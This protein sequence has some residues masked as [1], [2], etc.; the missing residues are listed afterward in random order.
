VLAAPLIENGVVI[1]LLSVQHTPAGAYS[2][3]DLHL[4][5]HLAERVSAAVA[6]ARVFEE[7]EDYRRTLEERVAERTRELQDANRDKER[8]IAAL[9]ERSRTLERES[10]EDPLTGIANRRQFDQRLSA[11][12]AAARAAEQ[13]LTLAVADLDHFKIVND[14]LGHSVGD[15]V[16]RHTAEIMR[17]QCRAVD[18]VARIG[19]EEF[20]LVLSG[21]TRDVAMSYCDLLRR[22]FESHD[23][24]SIHPQLLV[25][26]SIGISQ[27]DGSANPAEFLRAAD[28]Q[29]YRAKDAGRNRVA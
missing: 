12:I 22:A 21:M 2:K 11:E 3:A 29:L 13:P 15:E 18:L 24:R 19:G 26:L 16:L 28:V 4:I 17:R 14:R 7:L 5:Q 9:A 20:A 6:D 27:W 23:W 8:L 10:Q 25:T 1:G